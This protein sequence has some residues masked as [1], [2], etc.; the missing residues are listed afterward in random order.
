MLLLASCIKE[1]P[2]NA[3]C[4]IE[5]V[6]IS[7][8]QPD[9]IFFHPSDADRTVL[10]TDSVIMF[11]VRNHTDLTAIAPVLYVTAGATVI[12]ASG[13]TQ[14][15]SN[16]PVLYT[17]TSQDGRWSR[18]Y[19][20]GF[21]KV[22]VTVSDTLK[23]DFEKYSLE[24]KKNAYYVW[25]GDEEGSL[26]SDWASGNA[27]YQLSSSSAKP[28]DYPTIP[29][30]NGYDGAALHLIT[31]DTGD[32]G[33]MANKRLAPGN[34]FLGE[35]DVTVAMRFPM[36]STRF[37]KPFNLKP[38]KFTGYYQYSPGPKYQDKSGKAVEGRTDSG[39]IY[40]VL[41]R[42]HDADGNPVLLFGDDVQTNPNIVAIAKAPNVNK[43]SGWTPWEV[44]FQYFKELDME[45]LANFG[46]SLTVVFSSSIDGDVFQGA[47]GS[48][49][50]VDKARIICTR[51]E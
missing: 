7:V 8:D 40:A 39:S 20:I 6:T 51:E 3:E 23:I 13:S 9:D 44:E 12:P 22:T 43:T 38:V 35:F 11:N 14:D 46:Y 45:L 2:L 48:D 34:F 16:G 26:L 19:K 27:G 10:S 29:E 50:L 37:G 15:F 49:L 41:Y 4:D 24:P 21:N 18:R 1:E 30:P 31:R 32:F 28:M 33:V 25:Q 42:N 47:I 5:R 36:Q 17:V